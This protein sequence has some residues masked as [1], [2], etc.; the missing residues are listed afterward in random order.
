MALTLGDGWEHEVVLKGVVELPE[1]FKRRL[2]GG[3]RAFPPEDCGGI[4]GYEECCEAV[5]LSDEE[6][7]DLEKRDPETWEAM[8]DRRGWVGDWD[9]ERFD[10][11]ATRR[12]FD[13]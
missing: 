1:R 5:R 11:E 7:A 6:L 3:A 12:W 10:L 4:P 13:Y 8:Q 9:P 2:V